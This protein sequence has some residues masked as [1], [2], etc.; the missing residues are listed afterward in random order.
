MSN[1][2]PYHGLIQ[3]LRKK[4]RVDRIVRKYSGR[5]K[6]WDDMREDERLSAYLELEAESLS[7]AEMAAVLR[8]KVYEVNNF[9]ITVTK[10]RKK[11]QVKRSV[12][13]SE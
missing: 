10:R 12:K 5:Y 9:A 6:S 2:E 3:R 4:A 13:K 7:S 11:V 1:K 8:T